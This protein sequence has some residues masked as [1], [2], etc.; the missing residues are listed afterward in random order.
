VELAAVTGA[1]EAGASGPRLAPELFEYARQARLRPGQMLC[2]P[3]PD[4]IPH[5]PTP[6]PQPPIPPF[7]PLTSVS[8]ERRVLVPPNHYE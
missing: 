8:L 7:D 2:A 1:A 4:P 5:P 3:T 6:I